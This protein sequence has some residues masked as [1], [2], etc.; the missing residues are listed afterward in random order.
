M[1]TTVIVIIILTT[2]IIV[3]IMGSMDHAIVAIMGFQ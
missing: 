1:I 2:I 3:S